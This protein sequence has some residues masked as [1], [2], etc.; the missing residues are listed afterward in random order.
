MSGAVVASSQA[1]AA[2]Y[3]RLGVKEERL[4][5][6]PPPTPAAR[7]GGG[8][9][10]RAAYSPDTSLVVFLG[11]RRAYKGV[12][13]L[14]DVAARMARDNRKCV[15]AFV[16]PG[17]P[18]VPADNVIDVGSVA[19]PTK[20]AWLE[21]ADVVC[22]PSSQESWGLAVSEAWSAGTPVLTS[23]LP[24]F[25]ERLRESG[26]GR[27]V[28]L[29]APAWYSALTDI[30][31]DNTARLAMGAAG[32]AYWHRHLTPEIYAARHLALYRSLLAERTSRVSGGPKGVAT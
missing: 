11:A 13:L 4:V 3:R 2:L 1:D 26:G 9:A 28:S 24:V 18:L 31:T 12:D 21:A 22:L 23:D 15:F 8:A 10:L 29:T 6:L 16:G 17:D 32:F 20:D 30:L 5:I 19:G 27:A 25:V 14:L 7:R